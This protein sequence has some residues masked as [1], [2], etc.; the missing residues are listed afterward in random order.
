MIYKIYDLFKNKIFLLSVITV[1]ILIILYFGFRPFNFKQKNNVSISDDGKWIY[2]N[3]FGKIETGIMS[4]SEEFSGE[5]L[6]IEL[7]LK[8][9]G[10]YSR[11]VSR[12]VTFF[13]QKA[14]D[15]FLYFA[16]WKNDL[17]VFFT[18]NGKIIRLNAGKILLDGN[19]IN[20]T[21]SMNNSGSFIY[22]NGELVCKSDINLIPERKTLDEFKI[23]AGN[24]PRGKHQWYGAIGSI[25]IDNRYYLQEE[26]QNNY[27]S[28]NR[29]GIIKDSNRLLLY[30]IKSRTGS[31]IH[32]EGQSGFGLFI[33]DRFISE[34]R[35]LFEHSVPEK[36]T[37]YG[38]KD[39]VINI[40]GLI[41]FGFILAAFVASFNLKK[42]HIILFPL[43]TG[44]LISALIEYFQ[45]Y[46]VT[47][48][49]SLYDFILNVTSTLIGVIIFLYIKKIR[50]ISQVG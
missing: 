50:K 22:V 34:K 16:Q 26:I 13:N 35:I 30:N 10:S 39:I 15:E 45:I 46:L 36:L 31:V 6:S 9:E 43:V 8:G 7:L 5:E 40:L 27:L 37:R 17:L 11:Y 1:I 20:V 42:R 49:S 21:L 12:I 19:P 44:I 28:W 4:L 29:D 38:I 33:P 47:R 3:K 14:E 32:N 18:R 24:S 41:P 2:F 23:I 48:T 25:S